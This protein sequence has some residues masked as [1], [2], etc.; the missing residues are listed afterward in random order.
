MISETTARGFNKFIVTKSNLW[1]QKYLPSH[2]IGKNVTSFANKKAPQR[3]LILHKHKDA[4]AATKTHVKLPRKL[5]GKWNFLFNPNS[6][7]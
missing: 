4:A 2:W 3:D 5:L 7:D 6:R 1:I